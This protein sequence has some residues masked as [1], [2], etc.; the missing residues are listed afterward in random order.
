MK[1]SGIYCRENGHDWII[2]QGLWDK[3]VCMTC[4]YTIRDLIL[5]YS[6]LPNPKKTK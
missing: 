3:A 2:H 4:G 5:S 6:I 1:N